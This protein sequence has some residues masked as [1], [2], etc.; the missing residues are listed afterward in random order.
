MLN[1]LKALLFLATEILLFGGLFVIY[2]M[3]RGLYPEVFHEASR[4]LN[5]PMGALNTV[6]L[7]CSSFTMAMAVSRAQHNESKKAAVLLLITFLFGLTFM[8]VKYFEYTHKIHE[9]LLPG[10]HFSFAEMAHPK[11]P[12]F[13]SLYFMMTGLHGLHVLVGMGLI[14]WVLVRAVKGEFSSEYFTPVELTGLYWHL[15]DLIWI[16][17]FPLLYLIG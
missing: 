12:L 17:L 2:I 11:A 1:I 5:R 13:F 4:Y 7:I 6:V 9:G 14:F 16:Y 15:V 8:V 10:I 3:F